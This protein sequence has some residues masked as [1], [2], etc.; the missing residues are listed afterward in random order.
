MQ[1][2]QKKKKKKNDKRESLKETTNHDTELGFPKSPE[3]EN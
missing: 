3:R 1:N 2:D